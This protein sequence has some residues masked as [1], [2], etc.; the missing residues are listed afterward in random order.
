MDNNAPRMSVR[1]IASPSRARQ[2]K[3][4]ERARREILEAAAGVFARRGYAAATLAELAQASGYAP[5]SLYRYF[6]S[7]EE[8]FRSLV[9]LMKADLRATFDAAVRAAE[10]L[11]GRLETLLAAQIGLARRRRDIFALLLATPPG[12]LGGAHPVH[13]LR[14]G[15]TLYEKL[16]ADWLRRH[17]RAGELRC[18]P[19]LAARA[20]AAAAQAFH[21]AFITG[22][23][24]GLEPAAEAHQVV[25]LVLHG[26]A[27]T[28]APGP[29]ARRGA[30]P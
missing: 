18:P 13:E 12:A 7:K 16:M 23:D 30:T 10:P 28:P 27:A 4:R 3:A 2:E 17:A 6:A 20:M 14:A 11:T 1:V 15:A 21:H 5:P 19:D 8:I 9:E 22:P 29:A 26:I 24:T 25:D